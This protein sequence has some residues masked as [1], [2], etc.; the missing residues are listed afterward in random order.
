MTVRLGRILLAARCLSSE[1]QTGNYIDANHHRQ[2]ARSLVAQH[3]R[4]THSSLEEELLAVL[5]SALSTTAELPTET[6]DA[7]AQ[8]AYLTDEELTHPC[9][10]RAGDV[11][12][13]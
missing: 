5:A 4:R 11:D 9:L 12:V 13:R 1:V 3:A 2:F 6:S 7:L 10:R 8:L